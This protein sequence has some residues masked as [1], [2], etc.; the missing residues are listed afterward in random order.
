MNM[1]RC[2][3]RNIASAAMS[4]IVSPL[5]EP[6]TRKS[7]PQRTSNAMVLKARA[8]PALDMPI[9][10]RRVYDMMFPM[11]PGRSRMAAAPSPL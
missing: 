4:M 3:T 1:V 5:F 2:P 8:R 6:G 9:A 7:C 10:A 11:S